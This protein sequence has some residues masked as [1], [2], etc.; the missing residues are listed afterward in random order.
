AF[1]RVTG[2]PARYQRGVIPDIDRSDINTMLRFFIEFGAL[3]Q[4][5]LTVAKTKASRPFTTLDQFWAK[6][7][8]FRPE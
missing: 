3:T 1:S 4:H 8:S 5:D 6:Y 2:V 7:A